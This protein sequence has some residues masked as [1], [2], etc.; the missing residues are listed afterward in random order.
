MA[1]KVEREFNN[2][3]VTVEYWKIIN[4]NIDWFA[5]T[6]TIHIGGFLTQEARQSGKNPLF[7]LERSWSVDDFDLEPTD[8]ILEKAYN[9]LKVSVLDNEGKETN[10]FVNSTDC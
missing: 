9:K 4:T 3:G 10:L 1:L 8:N 6:I 7:R 5:K 2:S